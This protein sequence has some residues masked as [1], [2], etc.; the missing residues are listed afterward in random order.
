MDTLTVDVTDVPAELLSP[1]TWFDLVHDRQDINALAAQA[2]ASAYELL[3]RLGHRYARVYLDRSGGK[4][5]I[6]ALAPAVAA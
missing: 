2:G 5:P 1:G 4:A 6:P 3:T